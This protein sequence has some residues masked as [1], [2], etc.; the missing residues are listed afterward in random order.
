MFKLEYIF[1]GTIVLFCLVFI[2]RKLRNPSDFSCPGCSGCDDPDSC[3]NKK[4]QDEH[5]SDK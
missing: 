2:I 4:K 5:S 3:D 1:V